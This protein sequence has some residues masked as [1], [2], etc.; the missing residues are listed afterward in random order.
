MPSLIYIVVS[1]VK[2]PFLFFCGENRSLSLLVWAVNTVNTVCHWSLL[3][4]MLKYHIFTYFS[5]TFHTSLLL[6][7]FIFFHQSILWFICKMQM[8]SLDFRYRYYL[9]KW[10]ACG[11]VYG[12]NGS[13]LRKCPHQQI[14]GDITSKG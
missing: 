13:Y 3:V 14:Y 7:F 5:A 2:H 9:R 1:K 10:L 8:Q 11:M 6:N 4:P 12:V